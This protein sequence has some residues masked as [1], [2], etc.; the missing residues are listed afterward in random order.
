MTNLDPDL[1]LDDGLL[2]DLLLDQPSDHDAPQRSGDINQFPGLPLQL[3]VE[4]ARISLPLAQLQQLQVGNVLVLAEP[5]QPQMML[6][7]NGEAIGSGELGQND[8]MLDL[9][10]TAVTPSIVQQGES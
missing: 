6:R 4:L 5:H 9:R 3:T 1:M 8:G 2:D 10:L 7:V